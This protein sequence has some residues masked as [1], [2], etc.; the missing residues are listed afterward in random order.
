M[1]PDG[2]QSAP[3]TSSSELGK[4]PRLSF[5]NTSLS[6][7]KTSNAPRAPSTSSVSTPC[8]FLIAAARLAALG[9]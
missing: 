9:L 1:P 2:A 6:S 3:I 5:E 8:F 7:L 4:R